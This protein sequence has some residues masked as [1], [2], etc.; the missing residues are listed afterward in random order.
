MRP[1][2][3]DNPSSAST[4][5]G[6]G[7][8]RYRAYV[9][10]MLLVTYALN[11]ADRNVLGILLEPIKHEFALTDF[12]L[13]LLGGPAFA[14]LYTLLGLPV[15]RIADRGSRT[16]IL[17]FCL[18]LWSA[19]TAL[20]GLAVNYASL[21]VTRMGVSIGEAG[22]NPPANSLICDYFPADRRATALST[23]VLGVPVGVMLATLVGGW[24]AAHFGWRMAFFGLGAPGILL[25]LVIRV[26]VR[27]PP[28]SAAPAE[29]PRWLVALALLMR[30]PT[31]VH[32]AVGA[33]LA[34][35]VGYGL[36]QYLTS[37]MMRAHGLSLMM[38][39]SLVGIIAGLCGGMGAFASGFLADRLSHRFPRALVW[40][41]AI[42]C[43]L[44]TPLYILAFLL[45]GIWFALPVMMMAAALHSL[46]MG[47]FYSTAQG[48][49]PPHLRAT[50]TA[51]GL[52]VLNII[53]YGLG[54][55]AIG[56]LSDLLAS[57]ELSAHG[58]TGALCAGQ[59]IDPLCKAASAAGLRSAMMIAACGQLWAALHFSLAA[60][61]LN[62]DWEG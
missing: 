8:Q 24:V 42:G 27:E 45:Q 43:T 49:A 48:V 47:S 30:K 34:S 52:L 56:A 23:Y 10:L 18:G 58:L 41:P 29:F 38:S 13:G 7:T 55:P 17:T 51:L 4:G 20:C 9:L 32:V 36:N 25:A 21:F 31:F 28:R 26:T 14:V 60:R 33:G 11:T 50:S 22:C 40:L 57:G 54:P 44:A 35:F 46:Y 62:Q 19:M 59:N 3:T 15:A 6:Y 12:E 61:T 39:A 37:F 5:R 53:G 1:I 16:L 2:H